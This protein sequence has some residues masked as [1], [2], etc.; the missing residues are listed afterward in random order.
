MHMDVPRG[1]LVSTGAVTA[2]RWRHLR[3]G[4]LGVALV[5]LAFFSGS[6]TGAQRP[7]TFTGIVNDEMCAEA[8]HASMRM[9]PTDAE[10]VS[11]CVMSHGARYVLVV[12]R[13]VY[14]LSDQTTPEAFAAQRVRVTGTLN[15][16]TRTIQLDRIVAAT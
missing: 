4:L 13:D 6:V 16:K 3:R 11:A 8:G 5:G 2:P 14:I 1:S 10:C 15:Q 9:G 12:G 7:Q